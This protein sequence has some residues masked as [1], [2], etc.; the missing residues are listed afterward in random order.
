MRQRT[1]LP[2]R[3]SWRRP[4]HANEHFRRHSRGG[5][6]PHAGRAPAHTLRLSFCPPHRRDARRRRSLLS[7]SARAPVSTARCGPIE[8]GL[9]AW[10]TTS[11]SSSRH[12]CARRCW[13][14]RCAGRCWPCSRPPR[15]TMV[16]DAR[17]GAALPWPTPCRPHA[18]SGCR[19][20]RCGAGC[21]RWAGCGSPRGSQG[22]SCRRG[23]T[24]CTIWRGPWNWRPAPWATRW[25]R[26]KP[27]NGSGI[28]CRSRGQQSCPSPKARSIGL[29]R[30]QEVGKKRSSNRGTWPTSAQQPLPYGPYSY[31]LPHR[32]VCRAGLDRVRPGAAID[33]SAYGRSWP[34]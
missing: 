12:P 28:C 15:G 17:A 26:A 22:R 4:R 13:S 20:R 7:S 23:P 8:R 5:A 3:A 27:M 25:E 19:P 32:S 14:R 30:G 33:A 10:S 31:P 21:M 1:S 9:W 34:M 11:R 18:A 24:R 2:I 29:A 16:A 6:R